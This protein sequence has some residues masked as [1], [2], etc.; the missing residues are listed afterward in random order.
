MDSLSDEVVQLIFYGLEEPAG[1]SVT[2]RRYHALSTDPYVRA[3][4]FIARHGSQEALFHALGRGRLLTE[5]VLDVLFGLAHVSRYIVQ[6]AIHHYFYTQ[7]HFVK[8][9]WVRGLQLPVFVHFMKLATDKYGDIPRGKGEDD[10]SLFSSFIFDSKLPSAARHVSWETIREIVEIYNFIPFCSKDP[11]MANFPLALSIEPRLLPYAEANGFRMNPKYRDFVFRRMF[12]KHGDPG[13]EV[14]ERIC[15]NVQELCRLDDRMF[16]SRTVAAEVCMECQTND[17]AYQALRRLG[18]L[19]HL[20]FELSTLVADLITSFSRTRSVTYATTLAVI[21]RLFVDFPSEDRKVLHVMHLASFLQLEA[22]TSEHDG[23]AER[24]R[25]LGLQALTTIDLLRVMVNPFMDKFRCAVS[26][27]EKEVI[28]DNGKKGMNA[29]EL[30]EFLNDVA[31][32]CVLMGCNGA[33]LRKLSEVYEHVGKTVVLT[34]HSLKITLDDLP[35]ADDEEGRRKYRA[36]LCPDLWTERPPLVRGKDMQIVEVEETNAMGVD[37]SRDAATLGRITQSNL[38]SAIR[39]DELSPANRSRRRSLLTYGDDMGSML[40]YGRQSVPEWVKTTFGYRSGAAAICLTHA[41]LNGHSHAI[42]AMLPGMDMLTAPAKRVLPDRVPITFEH[43]Q[44]LAR[45][46]RAPHC[47]MF[48]EI[49]KGA[50]FYHSANDYLATDSKSTA[51][52]SSSSRTSSRRQSAPVPR[53]KPTL[54][55]P[56]RSA[57]KAVVSYA[58]PDSDEDD[59]MEGNDD[60]PVKAEAVKG[61]EESYLE[62]WVKNLSDLLRAEER[63]HKALKRAWDAGHDPGI[64]A[65]M[66][67]AFHKALITHM[68]VLRK[69]VREQS[70]PASG[71]TENV[72]TDLDDDDEEYQYRPATRSKRRKTMNSAS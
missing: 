10:G 38:T 72:D 20:R 66:K 11:L 67:N 23:I 12:E 60:K 71:E 57:A 42:S 64:P 54:K 21:K 48:N 44:M 30:E 2:S 39:C 17:N 53:Q 26:Y 32:N 5:R 22:D 56:R 69:Q 36:R 8:T 6:V 15:S 37:E 25:E 19:G 43:F 4:Y 65:P 27:A 62:K 14:V 28:M 18:K 7:T 16:L 70:A 52:S 55:R 35:A 58:V 40:S 34:T 33:L 46:G 24:L 31:R 51:K 68:R 13:F 63:N 3:N 47:Y 45:L 29:S 49:E 61:P 9:E 50:E 41:I 59:K 1:F